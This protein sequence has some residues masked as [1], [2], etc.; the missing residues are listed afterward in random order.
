MGPSNSSRPSYTAIFTSMI[1]GERVVPQKHG[2]TPKS[3]ILI[4]LSIKNHPFWGTP[5]FWKHPNPSPTSS[6]LPKRLTC[7][8]THAQGK[9]LWWE[10][11]FLADLFVQSV[12]P[13][14][15]PGTK[16]GIFKNEASLEKE[17]FLW[18]V[19][20]THLKNISQNG[21]SPQVGVKMKNVRNHHVVLLC[22]T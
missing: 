8:I 11:G 3:S 1:M 5:Y 18:L 15:S 12:G 6:E 19:A 7:C 13:P 21:S 4:E 22:G 2:G 10:Q 16:G 9:W 20:S 17:L 14:V